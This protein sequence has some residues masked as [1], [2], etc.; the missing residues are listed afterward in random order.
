MSEEESGLIDLNAQILLHVTRNKK[1]A[2]VYL[3]V[4]FFMLSVS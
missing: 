4:L 1:P 3:R 2:K